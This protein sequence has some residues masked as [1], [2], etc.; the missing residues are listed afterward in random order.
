M[1]RCPGRPVRPAAGG[2]A[3]EEKAEE[4]KEEGKFLHYG[5]LYG[6]T[7]ASQGILNLVFANALS[8]QQRRRSPTRTWASVSST[9]EFQPNRDDCFLNFF[10]LPLHG[11]GVYSHI[12]R[13]YRMEEARYILRAWAE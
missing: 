7:S 3:A 5:I 6:C 11:F 9:K 1:G 10:V 2:A 8:L 12:D 13:S 4:K